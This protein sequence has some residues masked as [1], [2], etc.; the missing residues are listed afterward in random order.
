MAINIDAIKSKL[1]TLQSN[2]TG[3]GSKKTDDIWKPS[4]GVH[5]VRIVPYIHNRDNPFIELYFHYNIGKRSYLSPVT[6]GKADPI[7]EFS[8]KL[9]KK[10]TKE[11]WSLGRKI[12]PKLRVYVP[13]LVRGEES[14]G[15]KFWGF[16]TTVY[17]ELLSYIADPDYGDITDMKNGR[18]ITVEIK[19]PEE[20]GKSYQTTTIRIKPKET[21]VSDDKAVVDLIKN[22]KQ[23]TDI[24]KEPTYEELAEALQAWASPED[25]SGEA[26][27]NYTT[28]ATSTNSVSQ[29]INAAFDDLFKG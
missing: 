23:I 6:F 16:G 17:Q 3:G 26:E 12:E 15:V 4:P 21:P 7:V 2:D 27:V 1:K 10:G 25:E 19:T 5:T 8:E 24:F 28:N 11:D 29:D 13:V 14:A 18:D 9:K 20:T 22:Q